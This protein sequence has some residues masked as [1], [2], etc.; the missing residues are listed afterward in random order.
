MQSAT[1]LPRFISDHDID[2]EHVSD[3]AIDVV[4]ELRDAGFECYLVG[5]CV[6]DLL[7]GRT[8]KDFDV[9][10]SATPEQVKEVFP[11]ARLIGRRFRIAHV[12]LRR[13]VIEVSTF[14]R[15]VEY[16]ESSDDLDH[17]AENGMLL[18]DN[19]Y[20]TMDDDAFRRDF[21][22]NALYYDPIDDVV[23]DYVDGM[24]DIEAGTI[25]VIGDPQTRFRE[26]PVRILRAIRFAAKLDF[27]LADATEQ[28]ISPVSE[29]LTAIP[30]A[31]LLDEFTKLFMHGA[32]V[33]SFELLDQHELVEILFPLPSDALTLV[34]SALQNTD[35]RVEADKP[36]TP[37]FLLASLL[38][39]EYRRRCDD[40]AT[41]PKAQ[42][43]E[44]Q[45]ALS[46]IGEQQHT[47]AIP[48]RYAMF[49]R[50][51]WQLQ[52]RLERRAPRS[53]ARLL[54]HRRFRAGYD[55]LVL[56]AETGD[57]DADLAKWWTEIQE[58][59]PDERAER[60]QSAAPRRRR[61]RRRSKAPPAQAGQQ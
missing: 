6:R 41:G 12:R 9:A 4:E 44:Y 20:G 21:T 10:T 19:V 50:D 11:R 53:L 40:T 5:G 37:A 29:F 16:D 46:V 35:A 39:E 26:D 28:A 30:S 18:R 25:R 45:A 1:H 13:E 56:R 59:D 51:V 17:E 15:N 33:R 24:D 3:N 8:P 27:V 34:M 47:I 14:R 22:V 52:P 32:A 49:I 36:V 60:I 23:I 38:W 7:L 42:D 58:L 57:V 61:R 48:K 31:R 43:E 54:E 2:V 55:F